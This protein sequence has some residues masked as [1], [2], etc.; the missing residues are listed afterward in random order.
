VK[1]TM[2]CISVFISLDIY[3][4]IIFYLIFTQASEPTKRLDACV[5]NR[6]L[7]ISCKKHLMKVCSTLACQTE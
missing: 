6:H 7:K 1:I 3:N 4:S 2:L 5:C